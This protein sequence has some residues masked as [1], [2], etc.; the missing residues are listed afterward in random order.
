MRIL[1]NYSLEDKQYLPMFM[2]ILKQHGHTGAATMKKYEILDLQRVAEEAKCQAIICSNVETLHELVQDKDA[3]LDAYRGSRYNYN[4][5]VF[6]INPLVNC[7]SVSYGRWL[8][9]RDLDKL[10][11]AAR[12]A[13]RFKFTVADTPD[14][15][16]DLLRDAEC[17]ILNSYDI[18]TIPGLQLITCVSFSF[19]M[20]DFSIKSYLIP[21]VDFT[22]CHYKTQEDYGKAIQCY[23]TVMKLPNP[24]I[25]QNGIYDA[26]YSIRYNA[27]PLN[28][29]FDTMVFHWC[30]YSELPKT[31]DFI[32]SLY[33]YDYVQ[34]KHEADKASKGKDIQSYW[35]Y[36]A[37]DS[38][39]TLRIAM[40]QLATTEPGDYWIHNYHRTFRLVY[41]AIYCAFE[42]CKIDTEAR[43]WLAQIAEARFQENKK[44]LVAMAAT[45]N[46]NPASPQQVSRF[47]YDIIGAVKPKTA[48]SASATDEKS[49]NRIAMQ[50]PLIARIVELQLA[51][52]GD[53]KLIS[54]YYYFELWNGNRALWAIDPTGTETARMASRKSA[55]GLGLQIQNVPTDGVKAFF[56]P[57]DDF[58]LVE[59]DKNKSEARC[60]G[61]LSQC[62]KMIEA[63]EDTAKDYYIVLSSEFFGMA[64]EKVT[65]YIRNKVTKK[66]IHGSNYMMQEETF[67]SAATPKELY[68]AMSQLNMR[69]ALKDFA[70][71]LLSLYHK[72]FPELKRDWYPSILREV[73]MTKHLVSPL[74]WTRRFFAQPIG[75]ML[76]RVLR[77]AVAH[78]PQN[79]SV[80]L[81]NQDF[82]EDYLLVLRSNG[83]VRLKAQ[84]HDSRFMQIRK[85][86]LKQYL[87][88]IDSRPP[89]AVEIHERKMIIP[90][91]TK[92]S[93]RNWQEMKE[94]HP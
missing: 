93:D 66:I 65:K 24:K 88:E 43:Y 78:Q 70:K 23:Q 46:F 56:I 52:K 84:I 1:F 62:V 3:T 77:Q 72:P 80:D 10:Q 37:K 63:L 41:P 31:L 6:I 68:N 2:Q 40:Q 76:H 39:N 92:L 14:Q 59:I 12:P 19:L 34:W 45:P 38:W 89:Q 57:D 81:L 18:E 21:F 20:P 69:L 79:L 30:R 11:S 32:A 64:Y 90:S 8:L 22:Q 36:C 87:T 83:D 74:G 13:E 67:I 50:H 86:K 4:I 42:G 91:E 7:H 75:S 33:L 48:T 35:A 51:F 55:F 44:D 53:Q 27:E 61:Y 16:Y 5:P 73:K 47:L 17:A 26:T 54:T 58:V 9:D 94:Y 25:A 85:G 49:L 82:W 29:V 60:V 15:W 28:F 71:W